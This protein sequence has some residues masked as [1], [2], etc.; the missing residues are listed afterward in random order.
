MR[1]TTVYNLRPICVT[2]E[3]KEICVTSERKEREKRARSHFLGGG[4]GGRL[5][6]INGGHKRLLRVREVE[7]RIIGAPT[8]MG[9]ARFV[10]HNKQGDEDRTKSL[11]K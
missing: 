5:C 2:S 6:G 8:I 1:S 11:E 4:T 7:T 9:A 10:R 3:R